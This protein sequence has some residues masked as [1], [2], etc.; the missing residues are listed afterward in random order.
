MRI[1]NTVLAGMAAGH[2]Y[3]KWDSVVE[4]NELV[5]VAL[6]YHPLDSLTGNSCGVETEAWAVSE[7]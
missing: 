1:H 5:S 3:T 7:E 4:S 2:P 6:A